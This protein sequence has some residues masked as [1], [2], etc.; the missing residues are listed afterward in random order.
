M[1]ALL[2]NT[3]KSPNPPHR[4][5]PPLRL[6]RALTLITQAN[7]Y[8]PPDAIHLMTKSLA[9]KIIIMIAVA[10]LAGIIGSMFTAP[11]IGVWYSTLNKP[12]WT[13]PNWL[14]APVW[15]TL[16]ALMGV[17]AALVWNSKAR[18]RKKNKTKQAAMKIYFG[19]LGLNVLWSLLFFGLRSPL[20][21]FVGILVLWAAIALTIFMFYHVSKRAAM[22]LMPYILWVTIAAALN[23]SVLLLN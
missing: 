12:S 3:K 7:L 16:Y 2:K 6:Q 15:L 14:F 5:L 11:A 13:P 8:I 20:Y 22:L 4:H 23:L 10:E 1:F 19:Q 17:A 21:G 18:D 9:A